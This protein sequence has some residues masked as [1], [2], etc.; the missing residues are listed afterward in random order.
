MKTS[1][2]IYYAAAASLLVLTS[3]VG[4]GEGSEIKI[5]V[6]GVENRD[7]TREGLM[8]AELTYLILESRD[9]TA[10]VEEFQI[11]LARGQSPVGVPATVIRGNQVA[12]EKYR[13][14]ARTGDRLVINLRKLKGDQKL[15]DNKI[16][17]IPIR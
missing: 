4:T 8:P 5:I 2:V 11:F 14:F 17:V 15:P 9:K 6:Q 16:I 10:G 1:N 7:V 13:P 3:F 12:L